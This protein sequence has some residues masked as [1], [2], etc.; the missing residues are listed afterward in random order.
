MPDISRWKTLNNDYIKG[1]FNNCIS[2]SSLPDMSVSN[3][4]SVNIF[5]N[6]NCI[7]VLNDK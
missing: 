4:K 1:L 6:N 7:S 5:I 2:L 3:N